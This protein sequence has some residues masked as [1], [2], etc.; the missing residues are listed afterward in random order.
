VR[1][2]VVVQDQSITLLGKRPSKDNRDEH[3]L[4]GLPAIIDAKRL[5]N[6]FDRYVF[7]YELPQVL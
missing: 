6:M 1:G 3:S 5:T 4:E 7:L 2:V